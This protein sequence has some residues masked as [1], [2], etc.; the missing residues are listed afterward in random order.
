MRF[1]K[2]AAL[3]AFVSVA[4]F[5]VLATEVECDTQYLTQRTFD[6]SC[7]NLENPSWGSVGSYLEHQRE[8][9][10]YA[11]D[12]VSNSI[13]VNARTISNVLM[14]S[15][16]DPVL[17]KSGSTIMST[18]FGQ[19]L[20]HDIVATSKQGTSPWIAE[21]QAGTF[22][23]TL[24]PEFTAAS[25]PFYE[26][27]IRGYDIPGVEIEDPS[28]EIGILVKDIS[29]TRKYTGLIPNRK[30]VMD[31][32]AYT[33]VDGAKKVTN[34]INAW[35]DLSNIYGDTASINNALR[36]GTDGKLFVQDVTTD[37]VTFRRT[38]LGT[39]TT[40]EMLPFTAMVPEFLNQNDLGR[41]FDPTSEFASGDARASENINLT[42]I[43]TLFHRYHNAQAE[44]IKGELEAEGALVE[45][46]DEEADELIFQ[47]TRKYVTAV[48]QSIIFNEYLPSLLG[49]DFRKH[50]KNYKGYKARINPNTNPT[51]TGAAFRYAHS[52]VP[53]D[54][55]LEDNNTGAPRALPFTF[56]LEAAQGTG[57]GG[58]QSGQQGVGPADST[59]NMAAMFGGLEDIAYGL[60][61]NPAMETDLVY[62]DSLRQVVLANIN[63][64]SGIDLATFD[65]ERSRELGVPNF[66]RLRKIY[67]GKGS[68]YRTNAC[69]RNAEIDS[70]KCFQ[71]ITSDEEVA[72]KLQEVYGKVNKVDG[73]IGM[74][75]E[76]KEEGAT[77]SPVMG[78]IIAAEFVRKR[79]ADR[80]WY[81]NIFTKDEVEE[82]E[83]VSFADIISAHMCGK[84]DPVCVPKTAQQLDPTNDTV[85]KF[86]EITE[87]MEERKVKIGACMVKI[88]TGAP[89]DQTVCMD[90]V[91]SAACGILGGEWLGNN[92]INS[93]GGSTICPSVAI[94]EIGPQPAIGKVVGNGRNIRT[95]MYGDTTPELA[96]WAASS[97]FFGLW[98]EGE[99]T[100]YEFIQENWP[101]HDNPI[102][103]GAPAPIPTQPPVQP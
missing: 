54:T 96:Q 24:D 58:F 87:A 5:G 86:G 95:Y 20:T 26:N 29:P 76:D 8:G 66:D 102:T 100:L 19:F 60:T 23:M 89:F 81:E 77:L 25:M 51:M 85:F 1:F 70:L 99:Q 91:N 61:Q 103:P 74:L 40:Y 41:P 71:K 44:R 47:E 72:A 80:F 53:N 84:G 62:E 73:I 39:T 28:D 69:K 31:P 64:R 18:F 15:D 2:K 16:G 78:A 13:D 14:K 59:R 7:N 43:H 45:L 36:S 12:G 57:S 97:V 52:Q 83:S 79:D 88:P 75:A 4:S 30:L 67:T 34:D 63:N 32:T 10:E 82:I 21:G 50:V 46:L 42:T 56:L 22:F 3:A 27:I 9:A 35:L 6:G 94:T 92:S 93:V 68:L 101:Y 55:L 90:G 11:A 38:P 49:D 48:Y 98:I 65:I 17:S 37:V 33:V